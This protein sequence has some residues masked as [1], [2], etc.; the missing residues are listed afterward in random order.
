LDVPLKLTAK[1]RNFKQKAASKKE[2]QKL[3]NTSNQ[4]FF[5]KTFE[6]KKPAGERRF[7]QK[8][9]KQTNQYFFNK[10]LSRNM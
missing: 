10:I 3:E 2:D 9:E 7:D 4:Y 6:R 8:H 1:T 5:D